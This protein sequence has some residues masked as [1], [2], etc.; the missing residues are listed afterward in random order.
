MHRKLRAHG[1]DADLHVLEAAPHGFFL[2][3]SP[4]DED[5]DRE[6]RQFVEAHCPATEAMK[7]SE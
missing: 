1:I 5:L 4:E 7:G 2:G 6:I 3:T